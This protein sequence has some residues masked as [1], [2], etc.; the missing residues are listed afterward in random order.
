MRNDL[1]LPH[2]IVS[3]LYSIQGLA[4]SHLS[5]V[6]EGEFL[7]E[8]DRLRHAEEILQRN[9]SQARLAI[10]ITRRLGRLLQK[11][12]PASLRSRRASLEEVWQSTKTLLEK[13]FSLSWMEVIERIP[14]DFPA[15]RIAP[16]ELEEILYVVTS[17]ALE[18][19]RESQA[20]SPK[21]LILRAQIGFSTREDPF[22]WITLADTGPGIPPC[23]LTRLFDPFYTTKPNGEGNG[24]GLFVTRELVL[25]NEGKITVGSFEGS[26]TTFTL[27]LPL[28]PGALRRVPDAGGK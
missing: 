11:Q 22:A 6:R 4:E 12:S 14:K 19:M 13:E 18:A 8:K 9:K 15:L 27:E 5:R 7:S 24:L 2:N 25:K 20:S 23:R 28:R 17:N 21:R 26:G 1:P 3:L 10:G 16:R